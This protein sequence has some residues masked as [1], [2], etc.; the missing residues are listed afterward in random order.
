MKTKPTKTM[1]PSVLCGTDFTTNSAQ[2]ADAACAL[3][4]LLHAPLELVQLRRPAKLHAAGLGALTTSDDQSPDKLTLELGHA[5]E[6]GQHQPAMGC[7]GIGPSILEALEAGAA[8]A[9]GS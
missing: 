4:K 2:A 1:P 3:A 7:R 5:T 9:D 8:I 6:H